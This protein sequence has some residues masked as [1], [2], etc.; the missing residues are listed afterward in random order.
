MADQSF[1]LELGA[2]I[3]MPDGVRLNAD[4]Y[5]PV[6][7]G[8]QP[9][10]L[11][12]TPYSTAYA[13]RTAS[14]YARAGFAV[15]VVDVRGRGD[16]EG[17]FDLYNDGA[18]GAACVDWVA[19]Q[20]WCDGQV[21]LFG[22]SYA[23]LNQWTI[24]ARAPSALKAIAPVVAP[25]PGFDADGMNGLFPLYNLC[26]TSFIRGKT[27]R[28]A[29]FADEAFWRALFLEHHGS[30]AGLDALPGVL[31]GT[32]TVLATM[33]AEFDNPDFWAAR[34]PDQTGF[35]NIDIPVLTATGTADNAQ[36]GALEYRRRHLAARPDAM[37]F[38]LLGPWNH[39]GLRDPARRDHD[40]QIDHSVA[41][42]T[43]EHDTL[44]AFYNWALRGAPLPEL[45]QGSDRA[46]AIY[47]AGSEVWHRLDRAA[48]ASPAR[49]HLTADGR[50]GE[51]PAL[52]AS[53]LRWP[54]EIT[55]DPSISPEADPDTPDLFT[56][57]GGER[58]ETEWIHDP[59]FG[60]F[61]TFLSQPLPDTR[62]MIGAPKLDI[63][64]SADTDA[65]DLACF[66]FE[67]RSDGSR[68]ILSSDMARVEGLRS[69]PQVVNFSTFRFAARRLAASGRIGLQMRIIDSPSFQRSVS[70]LTGGPVDL[71]LHLGAA[72]LAT[73]DLPL[74]TES[75]L[76][77]A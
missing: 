65:V 44:V 67:Q 56:L 34:V 63:T 64:I 15:V 69:G 13:Y 41:I 8:P 18:D 19:A 68:L 35:A 27:I 21:A 50:L 52:A 72:M 1:H 4:I 73:L 25:M 49:L 22:G 48:D 45:L 61:L 53:A 55:G 74:Y 17:A 39:A 26:W 62:I 75:E 37:H 60:R 51:N 16:S 24:A 7:A 3:P 59:A 5:R 58:P 70:R 2:T 32:D 40:P 42:E 36:R 9:A 14:A 57:L 20:D 29:L 30:G 46:E 66:V 76:A 23:G 38:L 47:V 43:A 6:A 10:L 77:H 33:I 11:T 12:L 31:G 54:E 71:T 28:P